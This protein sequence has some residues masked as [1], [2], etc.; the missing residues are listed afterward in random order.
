[1]K[2]GI[3]VSS[4]QG[5]IDWT[6]VKEHIDF[7]IIRCGYGQDILSQ[8]DNKYERNADECERLEIP[9][10]TYLYSYATNMNMIKSE[11]DH[12]LRLVKN[13]RLEYPVFIDIEDRKQLNLPKEQLVEIVE[14]YCEKI[15]DAGYYVG[16]YA[17]LNTF[18]KILNSSRLDKY[19]KWVAEW[20]KDFTYRGQSGMWQ[21]TDHKKIPGI[22]T[23]VD[24][25]ISFY[26]YPSIIRENGL[27]HLNPEN[28]KRKY[29]K[30]DT[31]YLNGPEYKDKNGQEIIRSHRN[32]KVTIESVSPEKEAIAPYKIKNCGYAK[33]DDLTPQKI[34]NDDCLLARMI[35]FITG[36]F[37][38]KK[39]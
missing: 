7:A 25:D 3:D 34:K 29:K 28:E 38:R 13:R 27:N 23:L 21:N 5:N 2:K 18:D 19:D 35:K 6:K 9:F 4:Y 12:T 24:G 15:E 11:V 36:L 1:M 20:N 17:S 31:L 16:I 10:G 8:D 39:T 37:K 14:Y 32:K 26:D 33:E 22:D 30:G